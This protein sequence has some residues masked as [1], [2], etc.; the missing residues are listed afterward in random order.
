LRTAVD[1]L[2]TASTALS[3]PQFIPLTDAIVST[4]ARISASIPR[5]H[6]DP[7]IQRFLHFNRY[8]PMIAAVCSLITS[9]KLASGD[10][11]P[12]PSIRKM[13]RDAAEVLHK[14]ESFL[15]YASSAAEIH[16]R[17]IRPFFMTTAEGDGT[18]GG[19]WSSNI[20]DGSG[21]QD[22]LELLWGEMEIEKDSVEKCVKAMGLPGHSSGGRGR[23]NS[24]VIV[25]DHLTIPFILIAVQVRFLP[26]FF[27]FLSGVDGRKLWGLLRG[28]LR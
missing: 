1:Q 6:K 18:M 28:L 8:R 15:E 23:K 10:W 5:E 20:G 27:V 2:I 14:A 16:P 11:S 25:D 22:H 24:L 4:I 26:P 21:G 7:H 12:S 19:G 13:E 3:R 9:S 17:R